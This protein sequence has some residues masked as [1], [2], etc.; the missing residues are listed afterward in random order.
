MEM[1]STAARNTTSRT[2]DRGAS[3][4]ERVGFGAMAGVGLL[5]T[6]LQREQVGWRQS[7]VHAHAPYNVPTYR[8]SDGKGPGAAAASDG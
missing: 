5:V 4:R 7:E 8:Q 3:S 1:V 2:M 6:E